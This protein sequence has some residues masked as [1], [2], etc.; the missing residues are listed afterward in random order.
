MPPL[1]KV[2]IAAVLWG[3]T[4]VYVKEADN[5]P[6]VAFSFFRTLIPSVLIFTFVHF[7]QEKRVFRGHWKWMLL[8]S[9]LNTLRTVL[10]FY[11][12]MVTTIANAQV[13]LY[14]WPIWAALLGFFVLKEHICKSQV[15]LL[16]LAFVGLVVMFLQNDLALS[17]Q[18]FKGLV[19]MALSAFIYS[20]ALIIFKKF[21]DGFSS[22]EV[23]FY[24]NFMTPLLLLPFFIPLATDLST[25]QILIASLFGLV[26]GTLGFTLFFSGL[27]ELRT[28]TASQVTYIEP[29]CGL[30]WGYF[31]YN[32][33]INSAQ[34]LGA[35]LILISTFLLPIVRKRP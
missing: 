7:R 9:S 11:A 6:A 20:L 31:L 22:F 12:F 30:M 19:A 34:M 25:K 26:N 5:M 15:A 23:V 32:E 13:M 16:G 29:L 18:H 35:S 3:A 21:G 17:N 27:K 28:A 8:G 24:Q 2:A 1:L 4:G 10:F 14:S 33:K